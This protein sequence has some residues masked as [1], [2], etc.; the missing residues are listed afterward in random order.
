[1]CYEAIG[2]A[3]YSS[4]SSSIFKWSKGWP[5]LSTGIQA[6][7]RLSRYSWAT[8]W[9]IVYSMDVTYQ[10]TDWRHFIKYVVSAESITYDWPNVWLLPSSR[11]SNAGALGNALLFNAIISFEMPLRWSAYHNS[12]PALASRRGSQTTVECAGFQQICWERAEQR[13]ASLCN[14]Y[15]QVMY[16]L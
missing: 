6:S 3:S 12:A 2:N 16:E 10:E 5:L 4:L 9:S 7:C 11:P 8:R 15:L 1:M 14:I 13:N